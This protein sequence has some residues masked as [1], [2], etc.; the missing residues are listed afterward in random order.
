MTK[1]ESQK[2]DSL[3]FRNDDFSGQTKFIE[4]LF[5]YT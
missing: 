5:E 3:H 4:Y 1:Y 2:K